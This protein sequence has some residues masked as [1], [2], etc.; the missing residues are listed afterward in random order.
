MRSFSYDINTLYGKNWII[1]IVPAHTTAFTAFAESDKRTIAIDCNYPTPP[2]AAAV[3]EILNLHKKERIEKVYTDAQYDIIKTGE[4]YGE[5][6]E[7]IE[8]DTVVEHH[9]IMENCISEKGWPRSY[10]LYKNVKSMEENLQIQKKNGHTQQY[11]NE[12]RMK[13]G[14]PIEESSSLGYNILKFVGVVV[15]D[16]ILL[17]K[18]WR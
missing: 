6:L 9:K 4:E 2:P 17:K 13:K 10:D 11:I 8:H 18:F 12:W 15:F 14:L 16:W 7:K 1:D 3:F 5:E